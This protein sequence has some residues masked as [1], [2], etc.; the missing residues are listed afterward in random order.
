M[1]TIVKKVEGWSFVF[2]GEAHS[3]WLPP[4]AAMPL[5]TPVEH[6]TLDVRIEATDGGYLL[7]W[8]ARLSP[9]CRE[10]RPPKA[11][12]TW[13][14]TLKDAEDD[15]LESFGIQASDWIEVEANRSQ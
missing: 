15:A 5:P 6:E 7:I 12:D 2:G 10:L 3:G 14:Q 8:T 11:G 9:T 1:G 4:G 13:H